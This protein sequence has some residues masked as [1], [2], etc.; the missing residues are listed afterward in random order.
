[1]I[2]IDVQRTNL[3]K[4]LFHALAA[5]TTTTMTMRY[6]YAMNNRNL[7]TSISTFFDPTSND[8]ALFFQAVTLTL[9]DDVTL[10]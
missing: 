9:Y 10:G 1:M 2:P 6:A 5:V 4:T 3:A 7:D 8:K